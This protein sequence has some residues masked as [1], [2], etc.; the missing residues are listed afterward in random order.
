MLDKLEVNGRTINLVKGDIT[1]LDIESFVYYAR[2][3]LVLGS[4]FGNAIT[5]RGGPG[6][7][8]ELKELGPIETTKAVIS[9]AG[10]LKASHII[11]AVGPKFQEENLET[12]LKETVTNSLQEAK[13]KGIK[14]VA[15]PPMGTG[16]YGVPLASSAEIMFETLITY[17]SGETAIEEVVI[18]LNDNREYRSFADHLAAVKQS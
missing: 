1:E 10:E 6:I 7:Q 16:F 11:H 4:G 2:T 15:F 8:K 17:L 18:C 3:D 14:R 13:K 5:M 9:S 12:K